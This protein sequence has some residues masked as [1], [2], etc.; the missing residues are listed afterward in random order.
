MIM[1]VTSVL[2]SCIPL[3]CR[4]VHNIVVHFHLPQNI[5]FTAN[6]AVPHMYC[7]LLG[8]VRLGL[9]C[10]FILLGAVLCVLNA[11][12]PTF[13]P[14]VLLPHVLSLAL[15]VYPKMLSRL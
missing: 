13:T 1:S 12:S 9:P 4:I 6:P 14:T 11:P 15:L 2:E 8:C 10:F 3:C 7:D 5:E